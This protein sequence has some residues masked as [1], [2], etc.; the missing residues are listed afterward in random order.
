ML[1]GAKLKRCWKAFPP[2][3]ECELSIVTARLC[4]GSWSVVRLDATHSPSRKTLARMFLLLEKDRLTLFTMANCLPVLAWMYTVV[5]F[6]ISG[7]VSSV[8]SSSGALST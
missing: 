3:L 7:S 8:Y 2:I 1:K 4:G 6:A 5:M